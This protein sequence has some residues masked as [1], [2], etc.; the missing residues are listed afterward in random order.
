MG[1]SVYP[2]TKIA[3]HIDEG[4]IKH[5]L[6]VLPAST[7]ISTSPSRQGGIGV[8]RCARSGSALGS[9]MVRER[10]IASSG[11]SAAC[12]CASTCSYLWSFPS[13]SS[14]AP[15]ASDPR[16]TPIALRDTLEI[17]PTGD[18]A[19]ADIHL[20]PASPAAWLLCPR[21]LRP[22]EESTKMEFA[23]G[24]SGSRGGRHVDGGGRAHVDPEAGLH[25]E[26]GADSE[27]LANELEPTL[28]LR[29]DEVDRR[30]GSP[31]VMTRREDDVRSATATEVSASLAT[32]EVD[33]ETRAAS[34]VLPSRIPRAGSTTLMVKFA[35]RGQRPRAA[36]KSSRPRCRTRPRTL[37]KIQDTQC[38]GC[39]R[40]RDGGGW[41]L[42]AQIILTDPWRRAHRRAC[43]AA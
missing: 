25:G 20:I 43:T 23:R 9:D 41:K 19:R 1:T 7:T 16:R 28:A 3:R 4:S 8:T 13:H 35:L 21:A 10:V 40:S 33:A 15:A 34:Y 27:G 31:A 38:R 32:M 5:H 24:C 12:A 30:A 36:L 14:C 29:G 26:D 6:Q 22:D 39:C 18:E 2:L 42:P 11:G 37:V 17:Y